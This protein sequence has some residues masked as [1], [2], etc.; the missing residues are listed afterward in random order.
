MIAVRTPQQ[1]KLGTVGTILPS[2][3][4]KIMEDKELWVKGDSVSQGF[5][6]DPLS[7]QMHYT[8]DNWFKTGDLVEY[9][10]E[11]NLIICGRKKQLIVLSNG[12]N[13]SNNH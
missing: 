5:Y 3:T 2:L 6:K 7:Q 10:T 12:K 13:N 11:G 8:K 1:N 4:V 9:D